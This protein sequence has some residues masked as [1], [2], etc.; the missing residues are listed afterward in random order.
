LWLPLSAHW[1]APL[2]IQVEYT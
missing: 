2:F 1:M